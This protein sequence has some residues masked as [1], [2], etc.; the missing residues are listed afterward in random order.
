MAAFTSLR[1]M[2]AAAAN[3]AVAAAIHC[4]NGASFA[5]EVNCFVVLVVASAAS[6][7]VSLS[8]SQSS[9]S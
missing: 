4:F 9:S 6:V 1:D 7:A 8:L 3:A 2:S 5:Y